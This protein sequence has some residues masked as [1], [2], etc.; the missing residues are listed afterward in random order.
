MHRIWLTPFWWELFSYRHRP[1]PLTERGVGLEPGFP[2]RKGEC[3]LFRLPF[4]RQG[5]AFGR[6]TG[7][8]PHENVDGVPSLTFRP[9]EH[10]EDYFHAVEQDRPAY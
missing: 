1:A 3:R 8:Q 6:W 10:P 2:W 7:E 5:I 9:L 4:S